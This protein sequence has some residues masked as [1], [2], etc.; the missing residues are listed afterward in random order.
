MKKDKV[1]IVAEAGINHNG[2][3][4][5]AIKLVDAASN[6]GADAVKF[7]TF[8]AEACISK[9][10]PKAEYQNR[11][12]E[13]NESQLEMAKKLEL[14]YESFKKIKEYC[15]QK[16]IE[17]L[18]TAF[19]I[20]S[21]IMLMNLG[22]RIIKIPSGDITNLPFLKMIGSLRKEVIMSTGMCRLDEVKD[23]LDILIKNGTKKENITIL[24]CNTEYPT[25]M[26]DVN[27]KAMI[28]IQDKLGVAVGY[29]DHTLGIEIPIAAVT[30]GATV[31]EKHLTLDNNL[32]GPDHRASIE[33]QE[34]KSMVKAIRN[35]EKSMGDGIK[36]P[37]PSEIKNIPIA[38]KSIVAKKIIKKGELFTEAN[39]TV[40]RPG[41]GI[42]PMAW[43]DYIGKYS[44]KTYQIDDLIE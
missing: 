37:S 42:T 20:E 19:D 44:N 17:F 31:I 30:L 38:R 29:S 32:P 23:A 41:N 22:Q 35:I 36:Q 28:T 6:A 16:N 10:A 11:N 5:N 33:P 15:G 27:L 2:K 7:Q 8:I 4:E 24:H 34:L 9:N 13:S 25:P 14:N 26:M 12:L 43:D 40:K 18:S 21:L 1:F 39:L 3:L